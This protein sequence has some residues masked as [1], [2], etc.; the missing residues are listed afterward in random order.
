M[1]SRHLIIF[2]F[3]IFVC[4]GGNPSFFFLKQLDIEYTQRPH[5]DNVSIEKLDKFRFYRKLRSVAS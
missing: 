3:A 2:F 5:K 4:L 1:Y